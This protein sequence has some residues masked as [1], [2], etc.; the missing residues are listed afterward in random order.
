MTAAPVRVFVST[1]EASGELLAADL[2]G[3]MRRAAH[4]RDA[5]GIGGERLER[6]GVR[7]TQR[8][9]RLGVAGPARR[10][11]KDSRLL[12]TAMRAP[13]AALARAPARSD[14]AGR[15]RRVQ[16]A[17]RADDPR[18]RGLDADLVLL[19]TGGLA[20]RCQTCARAV[21]ELCDP[22]TAFRS[23]ARLLSIVGLAD[24]LRRPPAGLD[25]RSAPAAARG[26][27]RRRRGRALA[28][29]PR[30]RDRAPHA[31]PA[32]RA[33]AL[34]ETAARGARRWSRLPTSAQAAI[35]D[36]LAACARR[37]RC[38]SCDPRAKRWPAPT[39]RRLPR[40]PRC[41]KRRCSRFRPSRST[42]SPRQP[43]SWRAAY[44]AGASSRCRIWC[45]T[46]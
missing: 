3:A 7:I 37:C 30:R 21:A 14:R 28:R 36:L 25:D 16:P 6:A 2:I 9:R 26:A 12:A 41:S 15:L 35:E 5:D 19:S 42:C 23:P 43:P 4:E 46:N 20:R 32:Q 38:S 27:P 1:G 22:L 31:A 45:S 10:A 29:Q 11:G 39:R 40:G 44:T 13:R 8:T 33:G 24:Q 17:S 34:R 18:A